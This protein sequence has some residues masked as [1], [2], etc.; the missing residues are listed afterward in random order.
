MKVTIKWILECKNPQDKV[1]SQLY[2]DE[3]LKKLSEQISDEELENLKSKYKEMRFSCYETTVK[4][5]LS[6]YL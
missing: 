2:A 3:T 6:E 5:M 1:W 4:R